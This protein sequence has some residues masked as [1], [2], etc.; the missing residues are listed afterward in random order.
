M[1]VLVA[2]DALAGLSSL[3]AGRAIGSGWPG[4][5]VTVLPVGEAGA[6]F[7]EAFA[8]LQGLT[9]RIAAEGS[10]LA[11]T[12]ASATVGAVQVSGPPG[13]GGIAYE[14]SSRPLGDA[15]ARLLAQHRPKRLYVD[16]AGAATHD[17]GAGLLSALGATADRSLDEGVGGLVGVTV[18]ELAAARAALAGTEL[19][20]VVPADQL[21]QVLLGLRG[22][23]SLAGRA[24]G[25][26]TEVLLET[27]AALAAFAR[28]AAD[29]VV[30]EPGAGACGGLGFA[31]LGLGGRLVSGPSVSFTTVAGGS[32][33]LVVTGCP[34]F[35]FARRGGGVVQAAADYATAVLSPCIVLAGEVLIGSREM[36]TMGI[37]AAYAAH[38]STLDRPTGGVTPAELAALA[39]RVARSWNW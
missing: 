12:A 38:E 6:G 17:G 19:I 1:R 30:T 7:V 23:T 31:V 24:A 28:A 33:D 36:R 5:S 27:D 32:F 39:S 4:G 22:I 15:V 10:W 14:G 18:V 20:G 34:A 16:L 2:T 35:D 9:A 21:G 37:E 29:S 13:P 25:V 26:E 3:A 11:V 8:E